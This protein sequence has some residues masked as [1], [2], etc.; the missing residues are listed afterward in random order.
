MSKTREQIIKD[1]N[2]RL[3]GVEEPKQLTE[4]ERLMLDGAIAFFID[5]AIENTLPVYQLEDPDNEPWGLIKT[6]APSEE[7]T[8]WFGHYYNDDGK[9]N[10]LTEEQCE[11]I[12]FPE[13]L[14][15]EGFAKLLVIKGYQAKQFFVED[16][17]N[18][19]DL[20]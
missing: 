4:K 11:E 18:A 19:A 17:I 12:G 6:D 8:K 13:D 16:N 14:H 5:G 9:L 2:I 1:L 7:I 3:F 20:V 15:S 10:E